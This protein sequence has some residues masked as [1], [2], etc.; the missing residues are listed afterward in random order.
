MPIWKLR[1]VDLKDPRWEASS[2]RGSAIV[3][4]PDKEAAR[5]A[6]AKAFDVKV[7]FK[8][9]GGVKAPPWLRPDLVTVERIDDPRFD[10][11]GAAEVLDP[12]FPEA[13]L[14]R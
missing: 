9:R 4:A 13:S 11:D 1:P 8:L 5:H 12:S 2:H 6:A 3:R 7:G 14:P 10:S